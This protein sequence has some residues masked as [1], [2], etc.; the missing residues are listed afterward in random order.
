MKKEPIEL[1]NQ[2]I[3]DHLMSD[4]MDYVNSI[5]ITDCDESDASPLDDDLIVKHTGKE[6]ID[7]KM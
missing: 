1:E 5:S 2:D 6:K 3:L 7:R 4:E